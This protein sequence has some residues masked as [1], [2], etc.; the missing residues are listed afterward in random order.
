VKLITNI[1]NNLAD[2]WALSFDDERLFRNCLQIIAPVIPTEISV[3]W[4]LI[5]SGWKTIKAK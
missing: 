2:N 5:V 3:N 4:S 1:K